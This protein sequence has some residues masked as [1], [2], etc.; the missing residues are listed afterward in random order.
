MKKFLIIVILFIACKSSAQNYVLKPGDKFP[1][2]NIGPIINAPVTQ[3]NLN[4]Y[5]SNKL[6]IINFW[7][8]WCSPC[9]PEM[10]SLAKLQAKFNN[11]IQVVGLSDDP[12][13]RLKK[14][15]VKKPSKIWLALDST[16]L[17]YQMLNLASVGQ[18]IV[19][20]SKHEIVA[21][22]KSD[23]VDEKTIRQLIKGVKVS[24]NGETKN[25]LNTTDKDP[26]G[27]DSLLTSNFTIRGYMKDQKG[28]SRRYANGIYGGR[29]VSY[30]NTS[31]VLLY[32][33]AYDI[34]SDK[35]VIYEG[36]AKKYAG[37]SNKDLLYCFDL[38]VR[39]DQKDSLH[40][41]M[42]QK[43]RAEMPVK[44][45]IEMR[46][47]DVYILKLKDA[48]KIMVPKSKETMLSYEF[49]GN[50]FDG[51]GIT[52]DQFADLY[53]SNEYNL[54]VLNESGVE[55]LYDIKTIVEL[56]TQEDI[57]KSISDIGFNVIKARR[58]IKTLVL[59][60]E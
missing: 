23:S 26:F 1:E 18:C 6:F 41:I 16:S 31:L 27:V 54:P 32:K 39:P 53:L 59:Y 44:A 33:Q 52:L 45:R 50:G 56:R 10:D 42:Q 19:V 4:Q 34:T 28:M 11:Q 13:T 22:L 9:I 20:N 46:D 7:G 38:L 17:L 25:Q 14:Y 35:Q 29:R 37:Y 55:G 60:T 2:I 30:F 12:I 5:P 57:N 3:L 21:L 15:L 51:K 24:S 43:L 48:G 40:S 8:T 47:T 58:K 36:T 49:G